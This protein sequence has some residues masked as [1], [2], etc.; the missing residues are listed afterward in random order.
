MFAWKIFV[1]LIRFV[2]EDE[3]PRLPFVL[4]PKTGPELCE[5]YLLE[6]TKTEKSVVFAFQ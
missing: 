2:R 6:K 5:P 1:S 3:F 4:D